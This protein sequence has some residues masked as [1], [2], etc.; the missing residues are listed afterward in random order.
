MSKEM[1]VNK[2]KWFREIGIGKRNKTLAA[3]I[4]SLIKRKR[5]N[6]WNE[7]TTRRYSTIFEEKIL[8]LVSVA[9]TKP[10][11]NYTPDDIEDTVYKIKIL[12]CPRDNQE[13]DSVDVYLRLLRFAVEEGIA[14]DWCDDTILYGTSLLHETEEKS[15]KKKF[16]AGRLRKSLT[17]KEELTLFRF[18][19][20]SVTAAGEYIGLLLMLVFGL[21]NN[22]TCPLTWNKIQP[23]ETNPN[24]HVLYIVESSKK[25]K[26]EAKDTGKT[27]NFPRIIPIP[28]CIYEFLMK[29][30]DWIRSYIQ[31][32]YDEIAAQNSKLKK[33]GIDKYIGTLR[34]VCHGDD[35]FSK[36]RPDDLTREGKKVLAKAIDF[37]SHS[38]YL[39]N[40]YLK[41]PGKRKELRDFK[42]PTSYL[43][44]RNF[45]SFLLASSMASMSTIQY[46]MGHLIEDPRIKR[47]DYSNPD[48]LEEELYPL[49]ESR[50]LFAYKEQNESVN[51]AQTYVGMKFS[52]VQEYVITRK[53]D[54]ELEI[55]IQA[56]EP[57]DAI[58]ISIS[59]QSEIKITKKVYSTDFINPALA[60]NLDKQYRSYREAEKQLPH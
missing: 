45:A 42:D 19:T 44:R 22:E 28:K 25:K 54:K 47:Y 46:L 32:H 33:L 49:M 20:K 8:P 39:L 10:I 41:L 6:E 57:S 34:I 18:L 38:Y 58:D 1:K 5:G 52:G 60:E 27:K 43:L 4:D 12:V 48:C 11:N 40:E 35:I 31:N 2:E 17:A 7:E 14:N 21:R 30:K 29:R 13:Y 59:C 56:F 36:T 26:K 55:E 24:I 3:C 37:D 16:N 15:K 51:C 9:N 23:L 50:P 53:N